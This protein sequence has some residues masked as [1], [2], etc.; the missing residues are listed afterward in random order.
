MGPGLP[1]DQRSLDKRPRIIAKR[2][3]MR[4]IKVGA[5]EGMS[6]PSQTWLDLEVK[7]PLPSSQGTY[8]IVKQ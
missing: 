6:V 1:K 7:K 5:I 2:P 8:R 3:R 4:L